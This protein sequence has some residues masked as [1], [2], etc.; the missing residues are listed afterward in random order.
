[1]H[2]TVCRKQAYCRYVYIEYSACTHPYLLSFGAVS[3][4]EVRANLSIPAHTDV[5]VGT[6]V[7]RADSTQEEGANW[8]LY[9]NRVQKIS[10]ETIVEPI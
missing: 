5:E 10:F 3:C 9:Y 7:S 2:S 4:E 1:M 8:H 6:G